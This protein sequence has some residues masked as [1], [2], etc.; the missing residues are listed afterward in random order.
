VRNPCGFMRYSYR[1]HIRYV[2]SHI[3]VCEIYNSIVIFMIK[4]LCFLTMQAE[5]TLTTI[6]KIMYS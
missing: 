4:N 1:T 6:L 3:F 2:G 5:K